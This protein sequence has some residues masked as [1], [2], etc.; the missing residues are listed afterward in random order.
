V[1]Y[2]DGVYVVAVVE[3]GDWALHLRGPPPHDRGWGDLG[4]EGVGNALDPLRTR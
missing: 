1:K 2:R 3:K 4:R